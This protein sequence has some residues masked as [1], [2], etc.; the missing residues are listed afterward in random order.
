MRILVTGAAGFIGA[1]TAAA[2]AGC[3]T[4]VVG[5]DSFN[6]YYSPQ[7]KHARVAA[8]LT[9][10]GVNCHAIDVA[11]GAALAQLCADERISI[12]VHL[13]A[14]AGV[15]HSMDAPRDY[16][17]SN[18]VGFA[19]VLEVCRSARVNHLVYA[20]SSSVYGAQSRVPFHEDDRVDEPT[21]LYAATKAANELMA[22]AY[23]HLYG[24][25]TTGLR[26]FTVY[27]PWGRPDMAYYTFAQKIMREEPITLYADGDV[28]RDFTYIDDIVEGIVRLVVAAGGANAVDIPPVHRVF[29]IGHEQPVPIKR[30]VHLLETLLERK[31]S[32]CYAPLPRAD[33]PITCADTGA[34][35]AATGYAPQTSLDDGLAHF[36]RWF[37][38]WEADGAATVD[39]DPRLQPPVTTGAP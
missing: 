5:C 17:H 30:F 15:R 34:L 9:P 32:I 11:D 36:V 6:D 33:V 27:G 24:L 26:F 37:L 19:E 4:H 2:L 31:A 8:L 13:A 38:A 22:H 25:R 3:G 20:S 35:R 16:V 7:L 21:S 29:N 14:Q 39:L 28:Q 12:I 23:T 1:H 18:L 10:R